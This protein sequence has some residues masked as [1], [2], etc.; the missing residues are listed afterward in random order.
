ML[1]A[2]NSGKNN[3]SMIQSIPITSKIDSPKTSI[4]K[5]RVISRHYERDEFR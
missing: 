1:D 3:D 4:A 2:V 5:T